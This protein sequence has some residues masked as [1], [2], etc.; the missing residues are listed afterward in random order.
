MCILLKLNTD[1]K[2]VCMC[3][4]KTWFGFRTFPLILNAINKMLCYL[5]RIVFLKKNLIFLLFYFFSAGIEFST[6]HILDKCPNNELHPNIN[7]DKNAIIYIRWIMFSSSSFEVKFHLEDFL[8]MKIVHYSFLI[9]K[10][11]LFNPNLVSSFY[12]DLWEFHAVHFDHILLPTY[13]PLIPT[14][15]SCPPKTMSSFIL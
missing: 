10:I 7:E 12:W 6:L 2:Y 4:V 15:I 11:I 14:L 8:E 1:N 9:L 5:L 3:M 13:S